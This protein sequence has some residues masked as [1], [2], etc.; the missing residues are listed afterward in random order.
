MRDRVLNEVLTLSEVMGCALIQYDLV[1]LQEEET[2]TQTGTE[3]DQK[4]GCLPAKERGL[5]RNHPCQHIDL[6]L[7]A[8]STVR[9]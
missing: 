6:Q 7:L 8:S 2:R 3:G 1:S 5:R 9:I 4:G